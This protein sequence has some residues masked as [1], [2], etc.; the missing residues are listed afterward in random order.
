MS[1]P[2]PQPSLLD[3]ARALLARDLK[4][5]WRRR[6]D[7]AQPIL[8]A[9]LVVALFALALGGNPD[10]LQ[11]VA[12][13]V[14]WLSVL[15]AGLLSLDTLFRGDAEDG[16]LEQWLLSPVPLPWLVA[17]RVF[18]HW[19]TTAFPLVLVSPLLAEL[20]QLPRAQL[21]VLVASLALG[22]PLLSLLGAVVAALTVGMRRSGILLAL[23]VLPLYV[24]V[25]V[26][27]AGAVA[28]AAQGFDASGAL[29]LLGAGLVVSLLLAPLTAA[30]A[31]RIANS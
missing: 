12:A 9:L 29:L 5:L 11:R 8:F 26:F 1:L 24:P 14:L 25:L 7:A 2:G 19:L 6:G 21:P 20:M 16:S 28:A 17:V 3:A 15:L 30:A 18:S 4:L 22:T 10:L 13:A 27:G 31:I 23:L